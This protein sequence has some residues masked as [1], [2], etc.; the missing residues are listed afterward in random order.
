MFE[1]KK[2][3]KSSRYT[4]PRGVK[5]ERRRAFQPRI[6][7]KSGVRVRSSY[8]KTTADFLHK[9][10]ITF[11]Y[12]PLILLAGKQYRPDFFLPDYDLFLEICGYNHMPFYTDRT[13]FKQ[14]LYRKHNLRA[15]FIRYN[16][17]GS[18]PNILKTS[19]AGLGVD[20]S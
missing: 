4:P 1:R 11:Q 17:K 18:L 10:N 12:E 6:E 3:R 19:L 9:N 8:E 15:I 7:T 16:G 14:E 13:K 5:L 20:F 2:Y